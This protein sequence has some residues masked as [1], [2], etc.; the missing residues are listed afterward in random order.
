MNTQQNSNNVSEYAQKFIKGTSVKQYDKK[1]EVVRGW[2]G[3]EDKYNLLETWKSKNKEKIPTMGPFAYA[4]LVIV[5]HA[6]KKRIDINPSE[7]CL[8]FCTIH[9]FIIYTT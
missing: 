6:Q 8:D 7:K 1:G 5:N 9:I 3:K 2:D 4:L